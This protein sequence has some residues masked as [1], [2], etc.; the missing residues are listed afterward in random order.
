MGWVYGND[1]LGSEF[2]PHD[3]GDLRRGYTGLSRRV[4]R[5]V[6]INWL[7]QGCKD[8]VWFCGEEVYPAGIF[9]CCGRESISV[10]S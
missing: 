9:A 7:Y 10:E 3:K 5:G 6:R 1:R 2:K 4:R 8:S